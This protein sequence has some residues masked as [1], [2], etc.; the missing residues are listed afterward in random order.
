MKAWRQNQ[1]SKINSIDFIPR[2]NIDVVRKLL[3]IFRNHVGEEN[4]ISAKQLFKKVYKSPVED[5]NSLQLYLLSNQLSVALAFM[6]Q[7][8]NCFVVRNQSYLWVAK[9]QND[10]ALFDRITKARIKGLENIRDRCGIAIKEKWW[11]KDFKILKQV[12]APQPNPAQL[13]HD[14]GYLEAISL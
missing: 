8:S 6:R 2:K 13:A 5:V 7:H 14:V 12:K 1:I 11:Q 10:Y 9:T 4:S 3:T